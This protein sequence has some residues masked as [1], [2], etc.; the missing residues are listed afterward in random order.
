[1]NTLGRLFLSNRKNGFL[2][3]YKAINVDREKGNSE[4]N[5]SIMR[6]LTFLLLVL[7]GG[8]VFISSCRK[9]DNNNNNYMMG[10]QDFVT[11]A[12]SSN[13]FEIAAGNLATTH[14]LNDS[15]KMFGNHMIADHGKAATEMAALA[16]KKGWTIPA[17]LVQK[18]QNNLDT[19][20]SLSGSAFDKKFASM[21]VVSHIATIALFQRAASNIGVPD[22]DLRNFAT[23]KLPTL[24]MHLADAQALQ[25]YVNH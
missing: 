14:G 2:L 8:A 22:A 5:M 9:D 6:K 20:T 21:M 18:D 11:Q 24:R 16:T 15:I 17:A 13:S 7:L 3:I 4:K 19:L 12:S 25:A 1:M 10:N 23:G